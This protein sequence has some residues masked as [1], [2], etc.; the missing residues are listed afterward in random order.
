MS[1]SNPEDLRMRS[2]QT[3]DLMQIIPLVLAT[4]LLTIGLSMFLSGTTDGME[5]V[6]PVIVVFGGTLVALLA[7]FSLPQ[8]GMAMQMAVNRGIRGGTTS[9]E[10]VR[11]LMKICDISRRDGLLGVA[12]VQT[13][14][15]VL[16]DVCEL[17]SDAAD[18]QAIQIHYERQ[19]RAESVFH[20]LHS[21]VF[22]FTAIYSVLIGGLGTVIRVVSGQSAGVQGTVVA[23]T[24]G[25]TMLP[26]VCG[27]SLALLM[28]ILLGRLRVAHQRELVIVD[29][30]YRGA[31]IILEDNNVQRLKMRLAYALPQ[32]VR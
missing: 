3:V 11:A 29:L 1:L 17:I 23:N 7:T 32:G 26:V 15:R 22:A 21:D 9:V 5:L 25:T 10:M 13:D 8:L 16:G 14:S 31:G 4:T 28:A 27:V 6:Q 12:D 20:K 24:L 2:A 18:D 19:I 30:A